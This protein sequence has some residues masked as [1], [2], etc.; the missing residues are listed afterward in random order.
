MPP[1]QP[2]PQ[3]QIKFKV[4]SIYPPYIKPTANKPKYNIKVPA[5]PPITIAPIRINRPAW[6]PFSK[7]T[8]TNRKGARK[9]RRKGPL[10]FGEPLNLP[11]WAPISLKPINFVVPT[12]YP[13][14][15]SL[16]PANIAFKCCPWFPW[17]KK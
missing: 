17:G 16:P 15:Y 1:F 8:K 11:T 7:D 3:P 2:I 14:N 4:P 10:V 12:P 6:A 5:W 13:P 9:N